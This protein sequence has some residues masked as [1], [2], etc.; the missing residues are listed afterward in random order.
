MREIAV[1]LNRVVDWCVPLLRVIDPIAAAQRPIA[2]KWSKKEILGHLLDS[3]GNNQQK[4]VRMLCSAG[5]LEFVGYSQDAW[6]SAQRYQESDWSGLISAWEGINRHLAHVIERADP[7]RLA[8]TI[9][10]EG[11]GPFRLDFVMADYVEHMKHHLKVI[12][13][14]AGLSSGFQNVYGA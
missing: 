8:N 1:S 5:H 7:S 10:I 14:E 13:P 12:L 4:F 11:K 2:G 9:S 6:V 3:A